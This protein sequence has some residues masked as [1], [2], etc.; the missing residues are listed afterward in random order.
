MTTPEHALPL[1]SRAEDAGVRVE[2]ARR[3]GPTDPSHDERLRRGII[4]T[5]ISRGLAR[6]LTVVFVVGIFAV[7]VVQ[8]VMQRARGDD[9]VLPELFHTT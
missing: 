2:A 3:G 5:E 6:V 8:E 7:P 9:S 4:D 1:D